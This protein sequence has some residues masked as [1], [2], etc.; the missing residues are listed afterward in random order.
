MKK[1]I[2]II[3]VGSELLTPF[4]QDTN[5]L[6]LTQKLNDLGMIVSFKTIV[7]DE[8][9]DLIRCIKDAIS[10]SDIIFSIGGLGPTTD[11]R[12]REAFADALGKNLVLN[13]NLL[14]KIERRFA[15]RGIAMPSINEKQAYVIEGADVLENKNGTAPGLWLTERKNIFV[16]LPGPP[17]ELKPMFEASVRPRLQKFQA[18]YSARKILKITGLTESKVETLISDLYPDRSALK[19]TVLSYPGQIELHITSYSEN[20]L[21]DAE[22]RMK[23]LEISLLDRLG[24]N[25]FS[26]SGKEIEEVIGENLR[27]QKMTVAIAESCT[28]GFLGHR[29]TNVSGSSDYFLQ[30]VQVYS[31]EAKTRLL[32]IPSELIEKNGAVSE[33][34]AEYMARQIREKANADYGIGITGVAGPTGGSKE[35]PV[36]LVYVSLAWLGGVSVSK[37]IF[38]GNRDTIKYQSSQKALD[39]LRRH[40]LKKSKGIGGPDKT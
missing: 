38:L 36:G 4:F 35:K 11:D 28:G 13:K 19:L 15:R 30:G 20:S 7:S 24:D 21:S 16:L 33:I 22:K 32:D 26:S 5:S 6:Y 2:E 1:K 9:D 10:R 17:R 37:R 12:T 8:W 3:A 18:G 25:V 14:E 27:D 31:N 29:I 34:V 39:M 23:D 40:M